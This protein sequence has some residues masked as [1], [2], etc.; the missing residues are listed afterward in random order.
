MADIKKLIPIIK[1]WEG[2]YSN[3]P[4]DKGGP[5]MKGI[6]LNTFKK[7][8]GE[9]KT[10]DDLKNITDT[11]W[12]NIFKTGYWNPFKADSILSQSIANIVVD[13]AWGSGPVTAIMKVQKVLG[14]YADGKVGPVTLAAI[15]TEDPKELFSKIWNARKQHFEAIVKKDPTQRVFLKGWMNRLNSYKYEG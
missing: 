8:Y 12:L 5:T 13:W 7:Y 3:H 1:K 15:N 14:V 9:D 2:G 10:A 6:T 4:M 11:Q